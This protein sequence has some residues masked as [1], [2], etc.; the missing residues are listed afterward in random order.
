MGDA[1]GPYLNL[2]DN[3]TEKFI[4]FYTS[5]PEKPSST[6]QFFDRN[7]LYVLHGKDAVFAAKEIY[8]SD[9]RYLQSDGG[10]LEYTCL[11]K[12]AFDRFVKHLLIERQYRVEVF[13]CSGDDDSTWTAT[14]KGSPGNLYQF[15]KILFNTDIMLSSSVVAIR[16]A[17][18]TKSKVIGLAYVDVGERRMSVTEF[19]DDEYFSNLETLIVQ[20]GPK[21]CIVPPSDTELKGALQ[22]FE[23]MGILVTNRKKTEFTSDGLVH[24]LN[25]LLNFEGTHIKDAIQLREME[26]S[27]AIT[28]LGALVK[29][30]ELMTTPGAGQF[31]LDTLDLKRYMK[32]DAAA[33]QALSILATPDSNGMCLFSLLNRCRTPQGQRLL[34]QWLKQPL[35]DINLINERL[36]V[37]EVLVNSP[38]IRR[39]LLDENL[40]R[41][42]DFQV[43][44]KRLHQQ[45]ATLQDCYKIYQALIKLP[46]LLHRLQSVNHPVVRTMLVQ[47]LKRYIFD[48]EKFK[49]LIEYTVDLESADKG[50]FYVKPSTDKVLQELR[51]DMDEKEEMINREMKK[52]AA[53][54]NLVVQ[55]SIKLD[56]NANS[57]YSFRV[58]LKEEKCLRNKSRYVTIST[59]KSGVLFITNPMVSI[60]QDFL[61]LRRQYE[62]KQ[63]ESVK[64]IINVAGAYYDVVYGLN[65]VLA[66]LDVLASFAEVSAT[67]SRQY[68]RPILHESNVGILKLEEVRHPCV[69]ICDGLS[70]VPNDVEFIKDEKTFY[71]ITGPNMGG[72]STYARSVGICVF[73]AQIGCFVPCSKA[74]ISVV[75]EIFARVGASDD[76]SKGMSTFMKEMMETSSIIRS[77]T[78]KSLVLIDELGRGTSTYEGCG[79][80]WAISKHLAEKTRCFTLFATHFDEITELA[81][82]L[83]NVHN[84]HATAMI[85]DGKLTMLYKIEP[86]FCN[87]SFGVEVAKVAKLP[88]DVIEDATARLKS[89]ENEYLYRGDINEKESIV[90]FEKLMEHPDVLEKLLNKLKTIAKEDLSPNAKFRKVIEERERAVSLLYDFE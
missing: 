74:E 87:R 10:K 11:K 50:E 6:I 13:T 28:C 8:K 54:L 26:L 83:P 56:F 75:D 61:E 62:E 82:E 85:V 57:G 30:L 3:E 66:R 90:S 51:Q 38:E 14:Y 79:I 41:I 34:S 84:L 35:R 22:I 15:E 44:A 36:D 78:R 39:S 33:V 9:V 43:L 7:G 23:R 20:L 24:E 42:P 80:A 73:M 5:L 59:S 52:V 45:K 32:L 53:D 2:S 77:A 64:A 72:K 81:N 63:E 16:A 37:V 55:K 70:Y 21:E 47:P 17:S 25:S 65:A 69:E 31:L 60:N 40:R 1:K 89:Y 68:V 86:G 46:G 58:T 19:P 71:V 67:A 88:D 29:Y 4:Q 48:M 49:G 12:A 76:L 27:V 18:G